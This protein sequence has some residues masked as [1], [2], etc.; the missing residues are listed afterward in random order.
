MK[1]L[2][3]IAHSP[4]DGTMFSCLYSAI[5]VIGDA[6]TSAEAQAIAMRHKMARRDTNSVAWRACN[7]FRMPK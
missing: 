4:G 6:M 2:F 5:M 3:E 7:G 1:Y